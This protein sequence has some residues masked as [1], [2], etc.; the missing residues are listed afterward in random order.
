MTY[1]ITNTFPGQRKSSWRVVSRSSRGSWRRSVRRTKRTLGGYQSGRN[2]CSFCGSV[3]QHR[4]CALGAGVTESFVPLKC[5]VGLAMLRT[6][7][8]NLH[9]FLIVAI[10]LGKE[11]HQPG[12]E[13][14]ICLRGNGKQFSAP[15]T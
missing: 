4:E 3:A 10:A 6:E 11:L 14:F 5:L 13:R 15:R 9:H 8:F 12:L 2:A 7:D 1:C